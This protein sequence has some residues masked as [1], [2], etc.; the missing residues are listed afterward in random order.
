LLYAGRLS[1]SCF[2][3]C[4]GKKTKTKTKQEQENESVPNTR[5]GAEGTENFREQLFG[6]KRKELSAM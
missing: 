5:R 6:G 3:V 1:A 4:V 2:D